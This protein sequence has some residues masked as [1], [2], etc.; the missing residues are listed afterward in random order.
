MVA[1]V[2]GRLEGLV[3]EN[4]YNEATIEEI[5]LQFSSQEVVERIIMALKADASELIYR[6][7][8]DIK[9]RGTHIYYRSDGRWYYGEAGPSTEEE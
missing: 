5:L 6:N 8:N 9:P 2:R 7:K 1:K 4:R 3:E